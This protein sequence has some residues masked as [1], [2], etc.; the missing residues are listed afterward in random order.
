VGVIRG[1]TAVAALS[2]VAAGCGASAAPADDPAGAT[3]GCA[4]GGE[5]SALD[6]AWRHTSIVRAAS[7]PAP[8]GAADR[9]F[10]QPPSV[11]VACPRANSIACDRVGVAIW[12]R[13]PAV[14]VTAVVNGLRLRLRAPRTRTGWWEGYLQ[15][16]GLLDGALRVTPD[17]GTRSWQGTHPRSAIVAVT[18]T[19]RSGA[20]ERATTVVALRAGWG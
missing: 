6:P 12:L 10:S 1:V 4:D 11:G 2:L 3:V 15:P 19:R 14:R 5:S 13:R 20:T 7:P 8:R 16:A 9:L 17:R 18:A